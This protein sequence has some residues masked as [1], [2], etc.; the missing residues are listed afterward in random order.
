MIAED[1]QWDLR[2]VRGLE[3]LGWVGHIGQFCA[4]HPEMSFRPPGMDAGVTKIYVIITK[5]FT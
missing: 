3:S 5:W 4:G 2:K 1:D